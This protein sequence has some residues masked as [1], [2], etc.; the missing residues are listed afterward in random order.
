MQGCGALASAFAVFRL[1]SM[2]SRFPA[3]PSRGAG[4][5][6]LP[7]WLSGAWLTV[8]QLCHRGLGAR[9]PAGGLPCSLRSVWAGG[10]AGPRPGSLGLPVDGGLVVLTGVFS[11]SA[12]GPR[13]HLAP[14]PPRSLA[15]A[16]GKAQVV[17][18]AFLRLVARGLVVA[19]WSLAGFL[20][21]E[22]AHRPE[23]LRPH[24]QTA[25]VLAERILE[26]DPDLRHAGVHIARA[27]RDL[28]SI[29]SGLLLQLHKTGVVATIVTISSR[30][31]GLS[32]GAPD[33]PTL[34]ARRGMAGLPPGHGRRRGT[35]VTAGCRG[36]RGG[37]RA[38]EGLWWPWPRVRPAA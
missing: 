27:D 9:C 23:V 34:P 29:L 7:L 36:A 10:G 38:R 37:V 32:G 3:L 2:T 15:V 11:R 4:G 12:L 8:P 22:R 13:F 1:G 21:D 6:T 5:G 33:R 30:P 25:A 26:A 24:G 17:V 35:G 18:L 28:W 14:P 19:G 20:V 16:C 31:T